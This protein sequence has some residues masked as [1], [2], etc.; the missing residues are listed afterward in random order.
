MS[1]VRDTTDRVGEHLAGDTRFDVA[2]FTTTEA[3]AHLGVPASTL[4]YWTKTRRL[5]HSLTPETPHGPSLPFIAVAEAQFLRGLRVAGLSLPAIARGV[6]AI[7]RELGEYILV[8]DRISHDGKS[9]LVN[10]AE[11]HDEPEWFHAASGQGGIAGIIEKSL[12][13]IT[14]AS[15]NWPQRGRLTAYEGA[16]VIIDPRFM[17][18]Q[19]MVADRGVRV[20]DV[21]ELFL[22]GDPI[23]TVVEEFDVD[24][25][26]VEAILRV[27]ARR[28]A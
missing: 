1:K 22:A 3:A 4:R 24:R 19:P 7:R 2:L 13:P 5:V 8:R 6:E 25:E 20:E 28:A 10:L 11:T 17:F 26:T 23:E 15:D 16:D 18:G 12:Q 14:W 21:A 27:Y 9:I